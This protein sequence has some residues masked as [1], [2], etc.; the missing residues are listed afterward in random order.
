M[1]TDQLIDPAGDTATDEL[2]DEEPTEQVPATGY[3]IGHTLTGEFRVHE[4]FHSSFLA[5]DRT[6]IVYLP[7]GYDPSHVRRYPVLYLHDGQNVFDRATSVGEEWGVDETA[8]ALIEGGVIEPLII[9]GVYNTG[10]HRIDEYTPTG[11][12]RM[13]KGG[14]AD[15]YG[16]MLVE[17]LKPFIDARYR[18]L[19]SAANTGLGGSS[20]G[21]L[22]TLHLGLRYPTVFSKLAVLSPSVWW[23]SR[24]IVREVRALHR[25]LPLRI[26]LDAGTCE[27]ERVCED[28]RLLR[29]ALV[30]KGWSLDDDLKYFEAEGAQHNEQSWGSRVD[31]ILRYLF[32]RGRKGLGKVRN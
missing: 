5:H 25:K 15:L 28:A 32:P 7:P 26:W 8:Q 2:T 3:R 22:L 11:S 10:E 30:E 6:V 19:P 16:R 24:V 31:P 9:V 29:D 21:G 12:A 27:G 13:H 14:Q 18:T 23:D 17:E 1:T 20:L 4:R